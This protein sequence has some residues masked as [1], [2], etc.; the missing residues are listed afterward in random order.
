MIT[1]R[2]PRRRG[3]CRRWSTSLER[4]RP[5]RGSRCRRCRRRVERRSSRPS[6]V[7]AV[8]ERRAVG[9]LMMPGRSGRRCGRRPGRLALA[10]VNYA[11][12]VITASV[13][14]SRRDSLRRLLHFLQDESGDRQRLLCRGSRRRPRRCRRGRDSGEDLQRFLH[15][16]WRRPWGASRPDR[17]FRVGD[18]LTPGDLPDEPRPPR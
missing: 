15:L 12:T 5:A 6:S 18:R 9:S 16:T 10:V 7:E 3:R 17:I 2:S 11:G 1:C 14:F 8:G 13:T 4:R